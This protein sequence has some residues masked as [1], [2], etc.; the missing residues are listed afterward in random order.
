[1]RRIAIILSGLNLLFLPQI[2]LAHSFGRLYNL[3]V[4][5]WIYLYGGAGAML[6][7]FLFIGY[8]FNERRENFSYPK[9]DLS[10][11]NFFKFKNWFLILLKVASLTLFLFT[12]LTGLL[13]MNSAYSNFNM[14]FFWVIFLL[15]LTYLTALVGNIYSVVNPWKILT[16]WLVGKDEEGIFKYPKWLGYYPALLF[17]FIFI[18]I[19]LIGESTPLKLSMILI[20]YTIINDLGVVFLGRRIWYKYCEFFGVFFRLISKISPFEYQDGKLYLRPPFMGILKESAE[21]PS[22]L[23]FTIFMISSTFFDGFKETIH[24]SRFYFGYIDDTLRPLLGIHSYPVFETIGLLLSPF[25]F[26]SIY[27]LFIYLAKIIAKN[28]ASLKDLALQFTFSLIPIALV[29]NVAHYY[30]LLFT[31]A[32]GIIRLISDP[33][34]FNWNLFNTASY[35]GSII[36]PANFIWHS[37]VALILIGHIASVYLAHLIVLK[38]FTSHRSPMRAFLS[39]VPMLVL[40]ITFTLVG[41]WILA[42]PITGGAS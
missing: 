38:I 6:V 8:F 41:L 7:S 5:F 29:Y 3:P 25:V 42:Q 19:E 37:E 40:M 13:G 28:A 18:W 20:A 9:I 34:G 12:I 2:T 31:E 17:Y 36:L 10:K 11:Y 32:P 30:T 39:Q 24:W 33:F 16:D 21:H 1:M 35:Y 26:L 4:P 14:T 27:L 22:L 23:L 15:G